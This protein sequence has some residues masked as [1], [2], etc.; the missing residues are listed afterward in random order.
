M[1]ANV[2]DAQRWQQRPAC[3]AVHLVQL[4]VLILG[5]PLLGLHMA[6]FHCAQPAHAGLGDPRRVA[7]LLGGAVVH[8]A[9]Q[10][11]DLRLS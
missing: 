4:L 1:E 10:A 8:L 9:R 5:C 3:L 11:W 6:A 7:R 2:Q